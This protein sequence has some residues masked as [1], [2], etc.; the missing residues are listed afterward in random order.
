MALRNNLA[1]ADNAYENTRPEV[2]RAVS[3]H[4]RHRAWARVAAQADVRSITHH[5]L[6][7]LADDLCRHGAISLDDYVLLASA[8]PWLFDR[9]RDYLRLWQKRL[10]AQESKCHGAEIQRRI[11]RVLDIL[12][13]W[14]SLRAA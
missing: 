12:N 8:P 6:C 3:R 10:A 2:G 4:D 5:Q 9:K 1:L 11:W 14:V 7:S 13:Y